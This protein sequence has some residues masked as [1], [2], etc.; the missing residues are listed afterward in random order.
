MRESSHIYEGKDDDLRKKRRQWQLYIGIGISL[1]FL[2][3]ALRNLNFERLGESLQEARYRW[4]VPTILMYF[5][6][7]GA[8]TWRWHYL[9]QPLKCVSLRHLFEAVV[10]GY[11]GN[12][13]YPFRIGEL[14]RAYVLRRRE[15]VSMSSGLATV[16]VERIFDGLAVLTLIFMAL[17]LAPLPHAQMR[18]LVA[19]ATAVFFSALLLFFILASAPQRASFLLQWIG[20]RFLPQRLRRPFLQIAQRFLAGLASLQHPRSI[21]FVFLISIAIWLA[22]TGK[23]WLMMQAF[24]FAVPFAVLMLVNGIINLATTLPSAPGFV[25]T[26]DLSGIAVLVLFGIDEEIAAAYTLVLHAALWLPSTVFGFGYML[27]SGLRWSELGQAAKVTAPDD[28]E[29]KFT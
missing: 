29:K 4:L 23:Y 13:I 14:L 27:Y 19:I 2:W 7:V 20:D 6:T 8:R 1:L 11:L 21:A 18:T 26:F 24:P 16:F 25:G 22:E 5:V 12:N 17:P 10:I 9:L 28:N 3:I 15:D